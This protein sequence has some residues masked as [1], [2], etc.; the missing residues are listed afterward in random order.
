MVKY[1]VP[2]LSEVHCKGNCSS[3]CFTVYIHT[4]YI[5]INARSV[6]KCTDL[7]LYES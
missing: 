3:G 1:P 5:P 6:L 2:P 4:V 7:H